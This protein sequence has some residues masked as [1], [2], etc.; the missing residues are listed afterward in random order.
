[1]KIRELLLFIEMRFYLPDCCFA[2]LF[3]R[4]LARSFAR[5][6]KHTDTHKRPTVATVARIQ[7]FIPI[8]N[9]FQFAP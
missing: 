2:Y 1:M 6:L 8:R 5:L 4:S 7:K 3:A 9:H